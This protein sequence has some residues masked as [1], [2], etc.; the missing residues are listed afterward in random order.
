MIRASGYPAKRHENPGHLLSDQISVCG[1]F[2]S[3]I[4]PHGSCP[5]RDSVLRG[6]GDFPVFS[7]SKRVY[8]LNLVF[9]SFKLD[10]IFLARCLQTIT[11]YHSPAAH[12]YQ[13]ITHPLTMHLFTFVLTLGLALPGV[14]SVPTPSEVESASN[15]LNAAR[16]LPNGDLYPPQAPGAGPGKRGL[17]YNSESNVV[18]SD[19]YVNSPYV[20]YGSNGDV[21][22]GDEINSWL[23]YLPAIAVDANLENSNW[24]NT[25]PVLIEGGTKA[26]FAF[27]SSTPSSASPF[28]LNRYTAQTNP[29]ILRRLTSLYPNVSRST[30]NTC[31]PTTAPFNLALLQS[32]RPA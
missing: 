16:A 5:S 12:K 22:R 23:S 13:K 3:Q 11:S 20:T 24:N 9:C 17:L 30:K 26:I 25:V 21:I 2:I 19:F 15:P 27:V 18:W 8:N 10:H 32:P 4:S 6:G 28:L 7:L 1:L 31:S 29:T 14:H